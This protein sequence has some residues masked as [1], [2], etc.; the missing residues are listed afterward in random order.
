MTPNQLRNDIQ[1]AC[2]LLAYQGIS[3]F[4][5]PIHIERNDTIARI[6]WKQT[7]ITQAKPHKFGS[8]E[9]YMSIIRDGSFT[10]VLL[11]GSLLRLSYTFERNDLTSHNLWY[12]PCPFS[13]PI[14]EL[15]A[16]PLLDI[17]EMYAES[18]IDHWRLKGPIRFD[19]DAKSSKPIF[20]PAS[21]VHFQHEYCRIPARKPLSPGRF[22]KFVFLNFYQELISKYTFL[23]EWPEENFD[24]TIFPIE[25]NLI[26][27]SW[28]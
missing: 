9:Q 13:I 24:Q 26:H 28:R 21:H 5:Q 14:D 4:S 17:I 16:D 12:Y 20:H 15:L 2:D 7:S 19:F 18:G 8:I 6:T 22:L 10:C 27:F 25:E 3:L 11:D 1:N 23:V